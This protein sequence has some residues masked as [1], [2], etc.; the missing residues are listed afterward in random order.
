ME[1]TLTKRLSLM[2]SKEI[3]FMPQKNLPAPN[4]VL[5]EKKVEIFVK[6]FLTLKRTKNLVN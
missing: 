6:L 2:V 4:T 1:R 3:N 5:W